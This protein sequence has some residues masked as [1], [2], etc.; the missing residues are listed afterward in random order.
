M[1]QNKSEKRA[2]QN[3]K[4]IQTII[5]LTPCLAAIAAADEI[6]QWKPSWFLIFFLV[7]EVELA[8]TT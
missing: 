5:A 2:Q 4:K 8:V 3:E 6:W 1:K 7:V